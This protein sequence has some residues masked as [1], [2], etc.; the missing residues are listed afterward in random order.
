MDEVKLPLPID[1]Y[2]RFIQLAMGS[3]LSAVLAQ[4]S[5]ETLEADHYC[6]TVRRN[7]VWLRYVDDML[8][9]P[10]TRTNLPDLHRLNAVHPSIQFI[11][12]ERD[13]QL[14]FLDTLILRRRDGPIISV[15]RKSTNKDD[16]IHHF[17]V[18]T[19]RTKE[20]VVIGFFLRALRI[21]SLEFLEEEMQHVCNTFQHL[22]Y[23]RSM[24]T[25]RQIA[26]SSGTKIGDIVREKRSDH[27]R[28]LIQVYSIPCGSCDEVCFDET[29]RGIHEQRISLYRSALRRHDTISAFVGH[30]DTDGYLPKWSQTSIV[31]RGLPIQR[32]MVEAEFIHTTNNFNTATGSHDLSKV[33]AH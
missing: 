20:G 8:A 1:D 16:F 6:S 7:V 31:K 15:Y 25:H 33:V 32:N 11:T 18:Y 22:H 3:P 2:I 23:P 30:L 9:V 12:E 29:A 28:P 21:C 27:N 19:K 13:E 24:L 10:L 17:S 14:P 4:L 5:M 26:T